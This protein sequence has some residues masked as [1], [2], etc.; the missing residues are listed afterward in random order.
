MITLDTYELEQDSDLNTRTLNLNGQVFALLGERF[1]TSAM[2][3]GIDDL[4]EP[5][6]AVS[7]IEEPEYTDIQ[8]FHL[9]F[10]MDKNGEKIREL[11]KVH[12]EG[13]FIADFSAVIYNTLSSVDT[14]ML[15]EARKF[16]E[17]RNEATQKRD[18]DEQLTDKLTKYMCDVLFDNP[19]TD[20]LRQN[21]RNRV[22]KK[23]KERRN[24]E[25]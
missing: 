25:K 8:R 14:R 4:L 24:G 13:E 21:I 15:A 17:E 12:T 19:P 11:K 22:A 7:L 18:T 2:C 1:V 10:A 23:I 16:L 6:D 9:Y 5:K 20:K 3:V